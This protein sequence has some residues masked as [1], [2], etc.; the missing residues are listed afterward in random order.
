MQW[1]S[2]AGASFRVSTVAGLATP[3][4]SV[5]RVGGGE[6]EHNCNVTH[7]ARIR[8]CYG[9]RQGE[10]HPSRGTT[11]ARV[12]VVACGGA[13]GL[14]KGERR[15]RGGKRGASSG[16]VQVHIHKSARAIATPITHGARHNHRVDGVGASVSE[17]GK[18]EQVRVGGPLAAAIARPLCHN[19]VTSARK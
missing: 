17:E 10:G 11:G 18:G 9:G 2:A 7:D 13:R 19:P 5:E 14:R 16:V 12:A 3:T 1:R 8:D 15:A 6:A 4:K